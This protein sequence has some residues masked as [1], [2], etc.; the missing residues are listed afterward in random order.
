MNNID[1]LLMQ[2]ATYKLKMAKCSWN[3]VKLDNSHNVWGWK[4]IRSFLVIV[5]ESWREINNIF[6]M[7]NMDMHVVCVHYKYVWIQSINFDLNV[8]DILMHC[9]N[10][11]LTL[12]YL[13]NKYA[14]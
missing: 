14:I 3:V 4:R 11:L 1:Y 13:L 8:E 2:Q 6:A 10:S 7:A 5:W 12:H 9:F